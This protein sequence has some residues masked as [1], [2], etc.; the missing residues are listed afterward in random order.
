MA[1]AHTEFTWYEDF[2]CPEAAGLVSSPGCEA[3]TE[4]LAVGI[5]KAFAKA[6]VT[7]CV[8]NGTRSSS[9]ASQ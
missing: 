7:S 6:G 9:I 2:V 4:A 5:S 8:L 3:G 1:N